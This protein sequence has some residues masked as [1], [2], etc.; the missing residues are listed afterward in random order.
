M[1]D[2]NETKSGLKFTVNHGGQVEKP[3]EPETK[4]EEKLEEE[5]ENAIKITTRGTR[6]KN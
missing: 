1:T 3:V 6:N 2:E 4:K 5:K